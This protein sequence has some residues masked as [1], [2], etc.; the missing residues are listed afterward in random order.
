MEG[1]MG[2]FSLAES[3]R[4]L[5]RRHEPL[6]LGSCSVVMFLV[7]WEGTSRG[8]WTQAL[9]PIFG[10][11]ARSLTIRP[12]FI[13]S[14]SRVAAEAFQMYFVTGEIWRDLGA[15]G[16]EYALGFTL[17]IVIGVPVGLAAGWYPTLYDIVEP[18][19]SALTAAPQI[20]FLPLFII[21]FGLGLGSKVAIIFLLAAL[22]LLRTAIE[23]A[24]QTDPRFVRMAHSFCCSNR[25]LF[26]T[27][28]L[29]SAVPLI[30]SG[31]RLAIG[32][33]MVGIVVGEIFGSR[34]GIGSMINVAGLQ[35]ETAKVFVGVLV[36]AT[37]GLILTHFVGHIE[38]R[39][40]GWRPRA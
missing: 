28:I 15:S 40:D 4:Q 8:W 36:I 1:Q 23:G 25:L 22:P 20:A 10:D 24:R 19:V 37:V 29:P 27:I 34:A 12:I 26:F 6:I 9:T 30:L 3:A 35:F 5:Y 33:A 13:S 38:R 7:V 2:K 31:L 21:W 14:P 39:V 16:L 11:A 32:Q 17:A 18:S